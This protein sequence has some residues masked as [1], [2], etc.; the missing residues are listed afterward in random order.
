[1]MLH[2]AWM[3]L[4]MMLFNFWSCAFNFW[5]VTRA[6]FGQ[7]RPEAAWSGGAGGGAS[8]PPRRTS[9]LLLKNMEVVGC[10]CHGVS[11]KL[12]SADLSLRSRDLQFPSHGISNITAMRCYVHTFLSDRKSFVASS[13]SAFQSA[14]FSPAEKKT[15]YLGDGPSWSVSHQSTWVSPS[16]HQ[17]WSADQ[18]LY[19]E[20]TTGYRGESGQW[21]SFCSS[22]SGRN[23]GYGLMALAV[24]SH[25]VSAEAGYFPESKKNGLMALLWYLQG[26]IWSRTKEITLILQNSSVAS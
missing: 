21:V 15:E 1:M 25:P 3:M 18:S 26:S 24:S 22:V 17:S 16:R 6:G 5:V 9:E 13:S 2:N 19:A 12:F 11:C 10:N 14:L 4:M 7:R 20:S 8:S 23:D